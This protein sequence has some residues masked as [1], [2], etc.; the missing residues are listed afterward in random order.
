MQSVGEG[1]LADAALFI[2]NQN[3]DI[4]AFNG[5][6]RGAIAEVEAIDIEAEDIVE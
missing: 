5:V 2:G 3:F 6:Q 4:A 1:G